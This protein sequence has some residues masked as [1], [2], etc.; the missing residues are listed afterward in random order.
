MVIG[1]VIGLLPC[2]LNPGTSKRALCYFGGE[3]TQRARDGTGQRRQLARQPALEFLF[4]VDVRIQLFHQIVRRGF[5]DRRM[6]EE[7]RARV[8]PVVRIEQLAIG[9][10]GEDR[11]HR[12]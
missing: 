11:N 1:G 12:E 2:F 7:L 4:H 5:P 8:A 3:A 6:L 9:P 10:D